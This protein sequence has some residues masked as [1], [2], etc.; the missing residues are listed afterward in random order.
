[1][2]SSREYA[3]LQ[4]IPINTDPLWKGTTKSTHPI[5]LGR[6]LPK[7]ATTSQVRRSHTTCQSP[8][9]LNYQ[10][11]LADVLFFS[12]VNIPREVTVLQYS[13]FYIFQDF[14][15]V[16]TEFLYQSHHGLNFSVG[17]RFPTFSATL[18]G[19]VE[20]V[21]FI[22]SKLGWKGLSGNSWMYPY[23][24]TPTG[25]PY[26][27]PISMG[28]NLQESLENTINTMGT[29]SGVHPIV[30]WVWINNICSY[31]QSTPRPISKFGKRRSYSG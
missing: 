6:H 13:W 25:N 24:R 20:D 15:G 8:A 1:M 29:L 21:F 16:S 18:R 28:Y 14:E 3:H 23:Q 9:G 31:G 2:Y 4:S 22:F 27:S 17:I 5:A 11:T 10:Q 12:V 19:G 7:W 30:P 26:I